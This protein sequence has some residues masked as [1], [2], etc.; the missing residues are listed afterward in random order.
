MKVYGKIGR[1]SLGALLTA[2]S[3]SGCGGGKDGGGGSGGET[4]A[5]PVTLTF[6]DKANMTEPFFK[7]NVADPVRAKYPHITITYIKNEKGTT[8]EELLAAGTVP[9]IIY[10]GFGDMQHFQKL[11][12]PADLTPLMKK[13]GFDPGKLDASAIET[14]KAYS[15]KG[16]LLALPGS[17]NGA[18]LY[19]NKDLFDKFG[20]AYPKDGMTWE[21]TLELAK[22]LTRTDGGV[23]YRGFHANYAY[24]LQYNQLSLPLVDPKTDKA[25]VGS[26]SWKR[27]FGTMKAFH[28]IEGNQVNEKT[29]DAERD[30]FLTDKTVAMRAGQ[31][32][33][34]AIT[35]TGMNWDMVSLPTFP[36]APGT[37]IQLNSPFFV[38]AKSSKHPD[39]A[40][41]AL[42]VALSEEVQLSNTKG[43]RASIL[44][45][46]EIKKQF[47]AESVDLKGK[48]T[49]GVINQKI[50]K[51]RPISK[52][53][54]IANGVMTARLKDVLTGK[55]DVNTALRQA[56]E[57][58]TKK[59][60]EEKAK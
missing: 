34:A 60:A 27:W 30:L 43:G 18:A 16:E 15:D 48:N 51:T 38:I 54:S 44:N 26:D 42:A 23:Q 28:E 55:S 25:L 57:E 32:F 35:P 50:A 59:I 47:G 58:I 12:L 10:S 41:Q 46:P 39:P 24:L 3:L 5:A 14:V 40:F 17:F 13:H 19:Y 21:Q 36:E 45:L 29:V 8:L 56:E 31:F 33:F 37:G 20:V 49:Q 9:D 52:Y 1:L 2:F 6:F 4:A 11:D 22:K 7:S 53:D